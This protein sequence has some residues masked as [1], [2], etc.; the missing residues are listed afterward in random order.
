MP[1][2]R[3]KTPTSHRRSR[4]RVQGIAYNLDDLRLRNNYFRAQVAGAALGD[5]TL[6]RTIEG[7]STLSLN[8]HD[9]RGRLLNSPL[10]KRRHVVD[11]DG[12][13]FELVKAA[14]QGTLAPLQLVYEDREVARLR[15]IKGP[16]KAF[17]NKVTRAE[18]I[19]RG[20]ALAR[21][22]IRLVCPQLHVKQEI[23]TDRESREQRVEAHV[24][25]KRGLSHDVK[26]TV[27]GQAADAAQVALVD[28]ALR[29]AESLSTPYKA[30]VALVAALI[31]ESTCRN[32]P[33][34]DGSS[35]GCLQIIDS[36]ASSSGINPR[37]V[38]QSVRGFL[39]GYAGGTGAIA[40]AKA[41]P[42]AS[43]GQVA[44][45]VQRSASPGR[46][47]QYADEA[48]AWVGAY[49]GGGG[50]SLSTFETVRYAFKQ[51]KKEGV[52]G[53]GARLAEEVNWRWFCSNGIVYLIAEPDL[54]H[55]IRRMVIS[56]STRGVEDTSFDY[57][58]G[59]AVTEFTVRARANE[60]A[61]PPGTVAQ[62]NRHGPA[63][64]RYVVANISAPLRTRNSL[65]DITL[66]RPTKALPEPAPET[67]SVSARFGSGE[68][69]KAGEVKLAGTTPGAPY[70][71]GTRPI[72]KQFVDP[73]LAKYGLSPGSQKRTSDPGNTGGRSDHLTSNTTAYATDYGTNNPIEPGRALAQ[74]IGFKGWQPNSYNATTITVGGL[75][76][77]VQ[78]LAGASI[79][80]GDHLHVGIS[81]A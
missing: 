34:G 81:R 64:G 80:H 15:R 19:A 14:R 43:S 62:V 23:A 26:L 16:R 57:D 1:R 48:R 20:V 61:A 69:G 4:L 22:R 40:Y 79:D 56:D 63:D 55:S 47:D 13:E 9:D 36:T 74:A 18:F 42:N 37:S 78:I 38:E 28:T 67:R 52:W 6:E 35:V 66:K 7:A 17:R 31:V 50:G 59:K 76:F 41:N 12:L 39:K 60:W 2:R 77:R 8:I 46:Y 58:V 27:K 3:R 51:G 25:R 49:N 5:G 44:Q 21:P 24:E 72:F 53:L 68:V 45:A 32:L 70:W 11:V 54:L 30:A 73:F 65:C 29:V 33:G 10:L 75:R 71:G